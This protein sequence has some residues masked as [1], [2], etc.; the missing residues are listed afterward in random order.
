M[1]ID[2]FMKQYHWDLYF[3]KVFIDCC[4]YKYSLLSGNKPGIHRDVSVAGNANRNGAR[5]LSDVMTP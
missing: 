5:E 2:Y 1:T 3:S 4:A